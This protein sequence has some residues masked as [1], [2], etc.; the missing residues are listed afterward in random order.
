MF[1]L[2]FPFCGLYTTAF[3]SFFRLSRLRFLSKPVSVH[4]YPRNDL[5]ALSYFARKICI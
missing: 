4:E 3:V 2:Q 1:L 5:Y